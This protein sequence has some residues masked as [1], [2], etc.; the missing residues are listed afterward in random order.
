[1]GCVSQVSPS[2]GWCSDVFLSSR[3]SIMSLKV[4]K[5]LLVKV[6]YFFG[7]LVEILQKV[8]PLA[9]AE[10]LSLKVLFVLKRQTTIIWFSSFFHTQQ[11]SSL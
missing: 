6:Q 8:R 5:Y 10:S 7:L 3:R 11:L 9:F 2:E 1:M 4:A